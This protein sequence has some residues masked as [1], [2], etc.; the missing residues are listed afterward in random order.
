MQKDD[1]SDLKSVINDSRENS[2]LSFA[3]SSLNVAIHFG[4]FSKIKCVS[5]LVLSVSKFLSCKF[6]RLN[7][8]RKDLN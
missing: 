3:S 7:L 8:I 1:H 2:L 6:L 4:K 5:K